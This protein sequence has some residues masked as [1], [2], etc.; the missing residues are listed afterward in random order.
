MGNGMAGVASK[1]DA[2]SI[3]VCADHTNYKEW[4]FI[5]DPSQWKPPAKP[6]T[7]VGVPIGNSQNSASSGSSGPVG[8]SAIGSSPFGGSPIGNNPIGQPGTTGAFGAGNITTGGPGG[9]PGGTGPTTATQGQQGPVPGQS[10]QGNFGKVCG[11]EARP[12]IR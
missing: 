2:D 6:N 1:L 3:M 8:S 4:E 12:G 9:G 5:Y 7:Q 10:N 11:M